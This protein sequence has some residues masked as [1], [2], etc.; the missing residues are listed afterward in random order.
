[1]MAKTNDTSKLATLADNQLD[2]VTGGTE[3]MIQKLTDTS[4]SGGDGGGG[5]GGSA[6]PAISAWNQ[7][8]KNYGYA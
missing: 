3:F 7:L 1:M 2:A 8:L 6:G 4:I 5:G